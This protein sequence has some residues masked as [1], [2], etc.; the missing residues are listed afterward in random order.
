M[1]M[2]VLKK[3]TIGGLVAA[4]IALLVY[5][6]FPGLPKSVKVYDVVQLNKQ[7]TPQ[8]RQWFYHTSQGSQLMPYTWFINLEQPD[9]RKLFIDPGHL[10]RFRII[11]DVNPENNP[12][13]LP[14]GFAKDPPDPVTGVENAGIT[15]AGCHTAQINYKGLGLRIDGAPGQLDLN[16]F[17]QRVAL[18]ITTTNLDS[19]KFDRF[20]KKVLGAGSTSAARSQLKKQVEAYIGGQLHAILQQINAD[21]ESGLKPTDAGF[22]RLDALGQGGNTLFGKLNVKNLRTLDGPVD[23]IPLWYANSYG[24]VQSN[25]SIRQPMARNIIEALAVNSSVVLPPPETSSI[26]LSSV[27]M[28]NSWEMEEMA[29]KLKAP[30][31]PQWLFGKLDAGK[32]ARGKALYGKYCAG[33]HQPK[34]ETPTTNDGVPVVP[35]PYPPDPVSQAAGK[36]FYH[37]RIF[38]VDVIGTD[39]KDAVNFATRTADATAIGLSANEPGANVIY[40][41]ISG[42]MN[43]YYTDHNIPPETQVD[44]NGYRANYWR[45]PKAYPAR[46]LA[47]IWATSPFL[48]NGSVPNLYELLSPVAERSA[49]FYTGNLEFDPVRVGFETGRFYGGFKLDTSITGNSN[50]GHEFT[51]DKHKG[52]IGRRF[53]EDERWELIEFLK[54]LRFEDEVPPELAPPAGWPQNPGGPSP[55]TGKNPQPNAAAGAP[56][57]PTPA[58]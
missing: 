18:A 51:D 54:A 23:I 31:W 34:L 3:L 43:R 26:Y 36:Q 20:A 15:C 33:C 27:R 37:L 52:R 44:W 32:V 12:D 14:V 11:P 4:V 24:W 8:E 58:G 47:G 13:R 28:K 21:K 55:S 6:F 38:S 46:P 22:G 16:A 1:A 5:L 7:W 35:G 17:L 19:A 56:P 57:N 41:I 9:N 53:T 25:S 10:T 2:S 30:E 45:G 29:A 48:H 39:P 50:A 42:I 40:K 49:T